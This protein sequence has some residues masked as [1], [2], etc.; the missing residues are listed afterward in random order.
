MALLGYTTDSTGLSK[1]DRLMERG[2]L[3]SYSDPAESNPRRARR[4]LK[5]DVQALK[6][7]R[8]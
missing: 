1:I 3:T 2:K 7:S 6:K 5:R 4:V 8:R